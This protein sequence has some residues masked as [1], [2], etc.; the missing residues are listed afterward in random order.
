MSARLYGEN[1]NN[2]NYM[3]LYGEECVITTNRET[4]VHFPKSNLYLAYFIIRTHQYPVHL[5]N[6]CF[7]S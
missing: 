2:L 4:F 1:R 6:A 3:D 7:Y 5:Y